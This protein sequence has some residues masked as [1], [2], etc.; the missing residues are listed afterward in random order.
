MPS[1]RPL[2]HEPQPDHQRDQRPESKHRAKPASKFW[3][4]KK[5][6]ALIFILLLVAFRLYLPTLAKD[7]INRQLNQD[8]LYRGQVDDVRIHLWRGAYSAEG[9][10]IRRV[11]GQ[12]DFPL[13]AADNIDAGISWKEI[14]HGAIRMKLE[15]TNLEV[16][17]AQEQEE[18]QKKVAIGRDTKE[19]KKQ[20]AQD[21]K[22]TFRKLVPIDV[23][24]LRIDGK[25]LHFRDLTSTP[26]V[27]LFLDHLQIRAENLTNGAKVSKSL[28]GTVDIR[29]RAMESGELHVVLYVNP[30]VAPPQFK[31]TTQLDHLNLTKLNDF[32]TAY[33]N[34]DVKSGTFGL[35]SEMATANNNLKGYI[36]PIIKDLKVSDLKKDTKKGG[37]FHAAWEVIVGA[38]GGIFKN[39]HENQ[40]AAK[41]QFEGRLDDPKTSDWH[42]R[43]SRP[44]VYYF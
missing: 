28:F 24:R 32:F 31:A 36:K 23:G 26:K 17:I 41:I 1:A 3:T 15:I 34:F 20:E 43:N 14:L 4:K 44:T 25:S 7:Y 42:L 37:V 5:I 33:G 2:Q 27:N 29:A 38:I 30:L 40:Q 12:K 9:L 13:L 16:N 35:Y 19:G 21:W 22:T 8:P 39:H 11:K 10:D 18:G 6:A